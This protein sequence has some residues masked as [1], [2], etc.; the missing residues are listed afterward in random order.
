MTATLLLLLAVPGEIPVADSEDFPAE[1]Q[2]AAVAATVRVSNPALS[3]EGTGVVVGRSGPVVYILTAAHNVEKAERLGVATFSK[4]SYPKPENV[5]D[6]ATVVARWKEQDVAV[7]RLVTGD[8]MPG[9]IRIC[10]PR[11][12][13]REK[14]FAGL[15]VGCS[16][17]E[18]PSCLAD[19]VREKKLVR[20]PGEEGTAVVWELG[21]AP[22]GGRSGGPLL[23][24][25]GYLLGVCSG[26]GDGK[27]YYC[28]V[29]AIHRLLKKNAL[30]WLY[31]EDERK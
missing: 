6:A 11:L 29:E 7:L 15:T 20:R 5:Y 23:D 25:R 2:V 18:A 14:N 28:H 17:A 16:K 13:P 26:G 31:D 22:Q 3:A 12:V 19:T 30:E 27:G 4:A 9:T 10:P 8:V 1:A 21:N 24:K